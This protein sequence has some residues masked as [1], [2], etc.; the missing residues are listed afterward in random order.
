MKR[1]WLKDA[2]K[3][4]GYT[5]AELAKALNLYPSLY[6]LVESGERYKKLPLP[7]A[8]QLAQLLDITLE[9]IAMWEGLL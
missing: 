2:R 5:Q 7:L 6:C 8:V 9:E 3:A 4:S 1:E